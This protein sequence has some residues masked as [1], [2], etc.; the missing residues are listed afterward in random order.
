MS[1]TLPPDPA[2]AA[3]LLD[4]Q[5]LH[6]WH[7]GY[8]RAQGRSPL[9]RLLAAYLDTEPDDVRLVEDAHG[10]PRLQDAPAR[11]LDFNWSHSGEHALV[12][13]ARGVV[14][15]VDIERRRPRR[16][17]LALARRFFDGAEVDALEALPEAARDDAFLEL[18]TAKE[19]LLK[20]HGRGIAYGLQRVLVAASPARLELLRFDGEDVDAW[21]LQRLALAPD[22]VAAVAWRGAKR[23]IR[24][25]SLPTLAEAR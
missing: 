3:A 14:P 5:S 19:A 25:A 18:W 11:G 22:L 23:R 2:A 13:I 12:A 17:A 1:P 16:Q 20:A 6:V 7:L 4:D 21:Q 9:R 8:R 10:R 24:S 15:G